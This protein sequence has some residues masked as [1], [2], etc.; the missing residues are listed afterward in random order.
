MET[1]RPGLTRVFLDKWFAAINS[2]NQLPRVH[3]K[4]LSILALS[5][6]IEM[7]PSGI[8]DSVKQG[9]PGILGGILKLF[10]EFPKA[11]EGLRTLPTVN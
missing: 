10:K 3:D 8:P 4:R 1:S 9:W 2:E 7:D 11:V 5:A 6:L